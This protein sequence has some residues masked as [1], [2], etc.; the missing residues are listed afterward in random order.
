MIQIRVHGRGGQGVVTAA[1]L[2]ATAAFFDG[3]YAQAFPS[4][5]VERSG[6]PIQAFARLD[7]EPIIT[8]E[9]IY[10]PDILVIQDASLLNETEVL[11][12][13][14]NSCRLIINSDKSSKE[15]SRELKGKIKA[16][17]IFACPATKIALELLGK[18]LVNTVILGTLAKATNVISL[19]SL[20]KAS[21][22]KFKGKGKNIISKNHA[23]IKSAYNYEFK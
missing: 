1:E 4:F 6:A 12:G 2:I 14:S 16:N 10:E 5:G 23:A 21:T 8:R 19:N 7:E 20:L 15:L 13:L 22:E 17:N 11:A 3:L 18:N 9:Q